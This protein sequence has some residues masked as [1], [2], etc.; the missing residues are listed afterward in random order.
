MGYFRE[1]RGHGANDVGLGITQILKDLILVDSDHIT[2]HTER[3]HLGLATV[4][5]CGSA[6]HHI[7]VVVD[8][9]IDKRFGHSTYDYATNGRADGT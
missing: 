7:V 1:K 9:R 3:E 5:D 2:K 4:S 6:A 8:V